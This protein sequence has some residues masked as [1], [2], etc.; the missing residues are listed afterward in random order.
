VDR[1]VETQRIRRRDVLLGRGPERAIRVFNLDGLAI[2]DRCREGEIETV[3]DAQIADVERS[4][5]R[6]A[7]ETDRGDGDVLAADSH[8]EG[9]DRRSDERTAAEKIPAVDAR[10]IGRFGI[11]PFHFEQR[12]RKNVEPMIAGFAA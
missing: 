6:T 5:E 4:G 7:F 10:G 12:R 8:R 2:G 9:R 3:V 11:D 1:R